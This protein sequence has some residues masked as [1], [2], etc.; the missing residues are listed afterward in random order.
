MSI[1]LFLR[2]ATANINQ[3]SYKD[4]KTYIYLSCVQIFLFGFYLKHLR[5]HYPD[6]W[7]KYQTKNNIEKHNFFETSAPFANRLDSYFGSIS[8]NVFLVHSSIINDLIMAYS[9]NKI[10][11]T[12]TALNELAHIVNDTFALKICNTKHLYMAVRHISTELSFKKAAILTRS[13]RFV[14]CAADL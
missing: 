7:S 14:I 8:S 9:G 11:S 5:V 3:S 6:N 13:A 12:T 4:R 2:T 1:L 10:I